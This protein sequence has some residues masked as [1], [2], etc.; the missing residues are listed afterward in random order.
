MVE[1]PKRLTGLREDG[2]AI[3]HQL[4]TLD[5]SKFGTKTGVLDQATLAR[6]EEG[7]RVALDF[8]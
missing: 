4:T 7:I 6:I 1:L 8:S 2:F 3:C 5:R